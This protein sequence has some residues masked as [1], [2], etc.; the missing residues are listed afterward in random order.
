M[1]MKKEYASFRIFRDDKAIIFP[2]LYITTEQH[3][4]GFKVRMVKV[5]PPRY[6]Y[7]EGVQY[8]YGRMGNG[9]T[10]RFYA[11]QECTKFLKEMEAIPIKNKRDL[12]AFEKAVPQEWKRLLEAKK[13]VKRSG[14]PYKKEEFEKVLKIL[15]KD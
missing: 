12:K 8:E 9:I 2:P 4:V 10:E 5:R 1:A 11:P 14:L 7:E 6:S 3:R 15:H 13:E